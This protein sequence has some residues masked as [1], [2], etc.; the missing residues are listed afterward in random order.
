MEI[1]LWTDNRFL[2]IAS[3]ILKTYFQH[4]ENE[5]MHTKINAN[6]K[7]EHWVNFLGLQISYCT[8][9]AQ[10]TY[11]ASLYHGIHGGLAPIYDFS[12]LHNLNNNCALFRLFHTI[13]KG[14]VLGNYSTPGM[15]DIYIYKFPCIADPAPHMKWY[16]NMV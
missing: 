16:L 14:N 7:C 6:T 8:K 11:Q 2:L 10:T 4:N 3:A 1:R 13:G 15:I 12:T 5:T 9:C